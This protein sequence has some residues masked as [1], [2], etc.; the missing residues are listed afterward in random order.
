MTLIEVDTFGGSDTKF[1]MNDYRKSKTWKEWWSVKQG[2]IEPSFRGSIYTRAGTI[3][4]HPILLTIDPEM[5]L[6]GQII[7]DK[8]LLRVNYDGYKDGHIYEVKTHKYRFDQPYVVTD[9]HWQQCQVEMYVYQE[10]Y[11]SW[12]LPEFEGLTLVS[13][14]LYPDEYHLE[15]WEIQIDEER[16]QFHDIAYDKHWI[17]SEYLPR[18]KEL[19]RAL[20][21]RKRPPME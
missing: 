18:V 7:H 12:F 19:A 17:K 3:F 14:A 15:P 4:E 10:K 16:I 8:Y 13:Y 5:T 9:D 6:D 2:D 1:I 21:K 20:K 11:K